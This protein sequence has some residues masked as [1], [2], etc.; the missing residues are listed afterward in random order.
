MRGRRGEGRKD[1][2]RSRGEAG[3]GIERGDGVEGRQGGG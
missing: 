1:R 2:E 3:R